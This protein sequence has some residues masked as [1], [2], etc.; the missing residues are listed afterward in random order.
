MGRARKVGDGANQRDDSRCLEWPN[1]GDG[2]EDLAF[3][4]EHDHLSHLGFQLLQL[5]LKEVE[6]SNQLSLLK[7]KAWQ[8][9]QIFRADALSRQALQFDACRRPGRQ[10]LPC[11]P[12]SG[13]GTRR[14]L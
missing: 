5:V 2:K 13:P 1:A 9:R 3:A 4:A 12:S 8:A 11:A 14:I 6:F 10:G 7:D